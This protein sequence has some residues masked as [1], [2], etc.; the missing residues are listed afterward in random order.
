MAAS[1]IGYAAVT[2]HDERPQAQP[3]PGETPSLSR[4]PTAA[5]A[6][7]SPVLSPEQAT[8]SPA[9]GL[10]RVPAL[11]LLLL[12]LQVLL[13]VALS[14]AYLSYALSLRAGASLGAV[15]QLQSSANCSGNDELAVALEDV[16]RLRF[17][18][19]VW[20]G[21]NDSASTDAVSDLRRCPILFRMGFT[22]SGMGDQLVSY[23]QN[24]Q[25]ATTSGV[26]WLH[27]PFHGAAERWNS[28]FQLD[29]HELDFWAVQLAL[30]LRKHQWKMITL[31]P[32]RVRHVADQASHLSQLRAAFCAAGP[33]MARQGVVELE[34]QGEK[35]M[36]NRS[37]HPLLLVQGY[38]TFPVQDPI[39]CSQA[40]VTALRRKYRWA[41]LLQPLPS[42]PLVVQQLADTLDVVVHYRAGDLAFN[43]GSFQNKHW[44]LRDLITVLHRL[45]D[46]LQSVVSSGQFQGLQRFRFHI[47]SQSPGLGLEGQP[48]AMPWAKFFRPV[49]DHFNGSGSPAL[50]WHVDVKSELTFA[51]M[52]AAP[53][54]VRSD[55]GFAV[56]AS[57]MRHAGIDITNSEPPCF[58]RNRTLTVNLT[59]GE[60]DADR[61]RQLLHRLYQHGNGS[62][63]AIGYG[64][65]DPARHVC[66]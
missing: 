14:A 6:A 34:L 25:V 53:I 60:L 50:V 54:L 38:A 23:V 28:F 7:S 66:A 56:A 48:I 45:D 20:G 2:Q 30:G 4:A 8:E 33:T 59:T 27:E 11:V 44:Q 64:G 16:G 46:L 57:L 42:P 41:R 35:V 63:N 61:F 51:A 21:L 5:L 58:Q 1:Y 15:Q 49:M 47:H 17:R 52:V 65:N 24:L 19:V 37:Q 12:L 31:K 9:L 26:N 32:P 29:L 36:I 43:P 3:L 39:T 22:V 18:P 13:Y 40:L 55:S 10:R 62:F